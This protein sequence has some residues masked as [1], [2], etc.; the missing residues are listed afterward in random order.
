MRKRIFYFVLLALLVLQLGGLVF[1]IKI[2]DVFFAN[3]TIAE[4]RYETKILSQHIDELMEN[5]YP[6]TGFL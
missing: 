5:P 3:E 1:F 6:K 2:L 4:M